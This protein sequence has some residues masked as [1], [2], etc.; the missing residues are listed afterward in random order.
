VIHHINNPTPQQIPTDSLAFL[1]QLEGPTVIHL[2]GTDTS[3]TRVLVTLLHGNEPSGFIA[4]H[5]ILKSG[6]APSVNIKFVI[7]SVVAAR[8]EPLFTHRMLPGA[9]DLNRCFSPPFEDAQG[10]LAETIQSNIESWQPEAVFDIHNTSGN[11]PDFGV[12]TN[13]TVQCQ[14]LISCFSQRM[15]VTDIRLHSLMECSFA[16]PVVTIECGGANDA[17]ANQ[18]AKR[19]ILRVMNSDSIF[20]QNQQLELFKHPHRLELQEDSVVGYDLAH[21]ERYDITMC[22]QVERFNFGTTSPSD[23][24]GYGAEDSLKH[25]R[26]DKFSGDAGVDDFFCIDNQQLKPK[27]PLKLFMVTSRADIAKSDC[28]FYFVPA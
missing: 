22:K 8:T 3:R 21:S 14:S 9:R 5:E 20:I 4:M 7:A 1:A 26:L 11:G 2:Q 13:D 15:I 28:L 24:I 12:A 25:L 10:K 27:I 18:T 16:G 19:G 23:V 17:Q 6:I